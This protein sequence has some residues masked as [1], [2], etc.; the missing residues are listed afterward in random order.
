MGI[1]LNHCMASV[2]P[3]CIYVKGQ[4]SVWYVFLEIASICA[5]GIA[6]QSLCFQIEFEIY[7]YMCDHVVFSYT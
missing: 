2:G 5:V 7:V 6:C 1:Q 3:T 4:F